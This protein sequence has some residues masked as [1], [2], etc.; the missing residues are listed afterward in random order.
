MTNTRMTQ[1]SKT[2]DYTSVD[3]LSVGDL[4][5]HGQLSGETAH[6]I[7]NSKLHL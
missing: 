2:K 1:M 7:F 3:K 4:E 5:L 6:Q